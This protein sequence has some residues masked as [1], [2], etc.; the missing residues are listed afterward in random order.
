M[1]RY[2]YSAITA[3]GTSVSG[4]VD[5]NDE[6]S[7]LDMIASRGLTPINLD[8]AGSSSVP[9]WN[10]ELRLIGGP[11][12]AKPIELERFFTSF[13]SLMQAQLPLTRALSFCAQQ[14]A[15]PAMQRALENIRTDVE[16]GM[17]LGQAMQQQDQIIPERL[18]VIIKL[19]EA[20]NQL[21]QAARE[22]ADL[23][24]RESKIAQQLTGALLYPII[25]V[26]MSV[27]VLALVVFYLT[28]TLLPV[29]AASGAE[30]PVILVMMDT[31]R[32]ALISGWPLLITGV[33]L[34]TVIFAVFRIQIR[35]ALAGISMRLPVAGRYIRQR[36]SQKICQMLA[37]LMRNGATLTSALTTAQ[38]ATPHPAYK[39]LLANTE[40]T[41]IAGG[42][43]STSLAQSPLMDDLARTMI[44]AGEESDRLVEVLETASVSL[45]AQ[46][47]ETV[48][49]AVKLI[50]P[51]LTLIIGLGV[52]A[53]ILSTIS[54]ILDLNDIAF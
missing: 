26:I 25:L 45:S 3:D 40:E 11:T 52:G 4:E 35:K 32:S 22:A 48:T 21:E 51:I 41:V 7:A 29:F 17:S 34:G 47:S 6:L 14:V 27:L 23:L 36:E 10:R 54:A 38:R 19:G 2:S 24:S 13:A 39:V 12:T 16:N 9:W 42:T 37:L 30:P 43:L 1:P 20:S 44:D 33:I 8:E 50:T 5:A 18:T 28:P 15:K 46:T 53:V 31:L 49:R